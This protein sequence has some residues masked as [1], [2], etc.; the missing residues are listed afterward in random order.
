MV[1]GAKELVTIPMKYVRQHKERLVLLEFQGALSIS[2]MNTETGEMTSSENLDDFNDVKI[3]QLV[4]FAQISADLH[5]L[6]TADQLDSVVECSKKNPVELVVGYHTLRGKVSFL[7]MRLLVDMNNFLLP[8]SS[9]HQ[10]ACEARKAS[11]SDSK[12]NRNPR[13]WYK[14]S[15]YI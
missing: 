5:N 4:N 11:G 7:S 1:G 2:K 15:E 14:H 13:S 9:L 10:L 8:I 12:L 6:E 3:G